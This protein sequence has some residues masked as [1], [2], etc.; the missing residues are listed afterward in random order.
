[1]PTETRAKELT[2]EQVD[3]LFMYYLLKPEDSDVKELY[4]RNRKAEQAQLELPVDVLK[5]SG[6]SEEQIEKMKADV[7]KGALGG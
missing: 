5:A 1:M 7:A 3:I 4:A 2:E 6:Y